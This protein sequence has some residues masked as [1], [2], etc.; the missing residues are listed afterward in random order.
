MFYLMEPASTLTDVAG[1][2]SDKVTET[3]TWFD[4]ILPGL[5][6]FGLDILKLIVIFLVGRQLIRVFLRLIEWMLERSHLETMV[7]GVLIQ[8]LRFILYFVLV[9]IMCESVG[10]A[11]S[12]VVA[13]IGSAGL[14]IGLAFQGA[15]SNFAGGV[16][17][18][19]VKPFQVGDYIKED[20]HQNEGVVTSLGLTY[21]TLKTMDEK[22]VVIPNGALA[23]SSLTN[24][25]REGRRRISVKVS[26]GYEEDL[27][28]AKAVMKD[29]MENITCRLK[30]E[31]VHI[32]VDE[33]ADSAVILGGWAWVPADK[34][35]ASQWEATENVKLAFDNHN[36]HIPFPQMDVYLRNGEKES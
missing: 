11:T 20:T 14:S 25:S 26:I 19:F 34:Y 12:S 2:A 24:Y 31:P 17:I 18:M 29:V 9:M 27:L 35:L 28:N 23:N 13:I 6:G 22:T 5:I 10:Y 30:E 33:L 32:F 16:L 36:I 7:R 1:A 21:T 15:L 8:V 3:I 4:K